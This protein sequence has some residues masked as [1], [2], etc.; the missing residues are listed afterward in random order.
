MGRWA[1]GR[2][3]RKKGR[4]ELE[5][6]DFPIPG[7]GGGARR[8]R[9]S[10]GFK[11]NAVRH[12]QKRIEGAQGK[13]ETVGIS[14]ASRTLNIPDKATLAEWLKNV[15]KYEAALADAAKHRGVKGKKSAQ[16]RKSL[17]IGRM[18]T[19]A[20]AER[21]IV[22]GINDLHTDGI[23]ARVSTTM[24]KHKVIELPPNFFGERPPPS[25]LAGKFRYRKR[26]T[27]WCRRFLKLYRF[28]VRAVTRQGQ[29]LPSGWP[30]IAVDSVKEWRRL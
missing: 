10:L 24:I 21:E 11:V 17:N 3:K 2:S 20:D 13:G 28:S 22:D 5:P 15:D 4:L 9:F 14:Y 19:N 1:R 18:R 26:L 16:N 30:A 6:P 7:L 12:S 27:A 25:D 23:S 8:K 29:K